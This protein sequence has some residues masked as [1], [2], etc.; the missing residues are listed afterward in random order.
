MN[1]FDEFKIIAGSL[2]R[3]NI[4][5]ALVEGVAMA[6]HG[7]PRFTKDIDILVKKNSF[8][9]IYKILSDCGYLES[10]EPWTFCNT[11]ITL[12]RFTKAIE[13]DLL[14]IDILIGEDKKHL[15]I[16]DHALETKSEQSVVRV[17]RKDDLIWLK[18]LRN[19]KQDQADIERLCNE[20]D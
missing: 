19:S 11:N 5:Y 4:S 3:L 7:E 9:D 10:S 17:A 15:E 6:F 14:V 13:D 12:H 16:I 1:V 8:V 18:T 20:K 2:A